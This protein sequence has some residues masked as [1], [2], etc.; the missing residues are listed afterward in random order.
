MKRRFFAFVTL[1]VLSLS[2]M[3]PAQALGGS[4]DNAGLMTADEQQEL[5]TRAQA[6][7]EAYGIGIYAF[8]VEDYRDH[9]SGALEDLTDALYAQS[10]PEE[11]ALIL[12]LSMAECDYLLIA[13]GE[14]A[15]YA[16]NDEG[17]QYLADFFLEDFGADEWYEG[18]STYLLW[19]ED[20]LEAARNGEPYSA[21]NS[22]LDGAVTLVVI[23]GILGISL[24]VAGIYILILNG[25]MKSVFKAAEARSY[26]KGDLQLTRRSDV[27]THK[28]T[29]RQ[30]IEQPKPTNRS[31]GT[32][33]R[34]SGGGHGTRGKF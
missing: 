30:K 25:K 11:D 14:N 4:Y 27:F 1:L 29:T 5:L 33:I 10:I 23:A 7:S 19:A 24:V 9:T 18:F 2:L 16:F 32:T 28:T 12:I 6:I 34:S 22:P 17:R 8:T 20:Y 13:Y 21:A 15:Q 26:V 31:G 3:V